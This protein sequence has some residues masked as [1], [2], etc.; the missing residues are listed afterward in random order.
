MS[1]VNRLAGAAN[2]NFGK[3]WGNALGGFKNQ[4]RINGKFATAS[5]VKAYA[6]IKNSQKAKSQITGGVRAALK[7]SPSPGAKKKLFT[8][9]GVV[10][11]AALITNRLNPNVSISRKRLSVGVRP[12]FK[13]GPYHGFTSHNIGIERRSD[14]IID[15]Y[16]KAGK[17]K[18]SGAITKVLGKG[19]VGQ[20]AHAAVGL[21]SAEIAYRGGSVK[22]DGSATNRRIRYSRGNK[23]V[24]GA[25]PTKGGKS[26][27]PQ[28]ARKGGAKTV[29]NTTKG[30]SGQVKLNSR[31]QRR[32]GGKK[33][34]KSK[35]GTY[36]K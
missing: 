1:K 33:K 3:P 16:E 34:K 12:D 8:A 30:G 2:P 25:P 29:T 27:K 26:T 18:A 11:G 22:V 20:L 7:Y 24:P 28:G 21:D 13:L 23:A 36:T 35:K 31:A 4:P 6:K 9:T 14:D 10:I 15:R 5:Q 17:E 32:G 19:K